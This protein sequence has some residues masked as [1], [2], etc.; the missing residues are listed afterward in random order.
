VAKISPVSLSCAKIVV[1]DEKEKISKQEIKYFIS[2]L[3]E[4]K[5]VLR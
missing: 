3:W 4:G 1:K 5:D 2:M